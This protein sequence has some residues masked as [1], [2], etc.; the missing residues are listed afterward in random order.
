MRR[1][2]AI[3]SSRGRTAAAYRDEAGE[4]RM[5]QSTC[6]HLG[7]DLRFSAGDKCFECP[8]HGSCFDVDGSVL[9]GP[10]VKALRAVDSTD[11]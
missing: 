11:W 9:H 8:C 2:G 3:L 7:C 10:A 4:L 6:T 1:D 5:F